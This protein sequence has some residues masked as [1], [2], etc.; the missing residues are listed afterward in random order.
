MTIILTQKKTKRE[1]V[2]QVEEI[3][4][5]IRKCVGDGSKCEP[6][7]RKRTPLI[8]W[9]YDRDNVYMAIS[10]IAVRIRIWLRDQCSHAVVGVW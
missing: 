7:M 3:V 4:D 6:E 8:N 9:S 1:S 5:V 10:A 2:Q